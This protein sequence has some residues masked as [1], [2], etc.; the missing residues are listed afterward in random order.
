MDKLAEFCHDKYVED[1][2]REV[3]KELKV[4][5]AKHNS[6]TSPDLPHKAPPHN[7]HRR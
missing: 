2:A 7:D 1:L 6:K 5:L 3:S 4:D